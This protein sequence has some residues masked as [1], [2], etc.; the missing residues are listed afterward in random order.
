LPGSWRRKPSSTGP[1]VACRLQKLGRSTS[2]KARKR[3][4][5]SKD[6]RTVF[7]AKAGR[8]VLAN[9]VRRLSSQPLKRMAR[10]F[11]SSNRGSSS[12]EGVLSPERC[13]LNKGYTLRTLGVV[14][15]FCCMRKLVA[16]GRSREGWS[17]LREHHRST[18]ERQ[19]SFGF[20]VRLPQ[21]KSA[22]GQP[23]SG[24]AAPQ[25]QR[26]RAAPQPRSKL[27]RRKTAVSEGTP[28]SAN[29]SGR[30]FGADSE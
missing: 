26:S 13:P 29:C 15:D 6:R 18:R 1:C 22:G 20:V 17:L 14:I 3:M 5:A 7:L 23:A 8:S 30:F 12:V 4:R 25:M 16:K 19:R 28:G 21:L 11:P 9:R 24:H 2:P 10:R 27:P